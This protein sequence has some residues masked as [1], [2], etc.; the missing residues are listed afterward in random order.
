VLEAAARV[1]ETS[2]RPSERARPSDA[3]GGCSGRYPQGE[4]S[5]SSSG[6]RSVC[7]PV[8]HRPGVQRRTI[9]CGV[10][11]RRM[12]T[13]ACSVRVIHEPGLAP[14]RVHGLRH[15]VQRVLG[16]SPSGA[17]AALDLVS[18]RR[19]RRVKAACRA[20]SESRQ[21]RIPVSLPL[22]TCGHPHEPRSAS[23]APN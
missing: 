9:P 10:H 17:R 5:R 2:A 1:A 19:G 18:S 3:S 14:H 7:L 23:W 6:L 15:H 22:L 20:S 21:P 12:G 11:R 8:S 4:R 16:G 13:S